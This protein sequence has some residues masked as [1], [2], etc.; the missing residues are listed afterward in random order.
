[1]KVPPSSNKVLAR[2]GL[3][4]DLQI[5]EATEQ[6]K[7]PVS[8]SDITAA[9][10]KCPAAC[11][12]ARATSRQRHVIQ[13]WFWPSVA[14]VHI[15]D[16]EGERLLRYIP[17]SGT[18]TE[19]LSFDVSK[20]FVPGVYLLLPPGSCT[21]A[22]ALERSRKRKGRHQPTNQSGITRKQRFSIRAHWSTK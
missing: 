22:A 11:V 19:I 16:G 9:Q 10:A 13:A 21:R 2:L 14:Y 3:R 7:I 1:M 15:H 4:E 18:R 12:L 20:G 5:V 17:A 6:R 8:I